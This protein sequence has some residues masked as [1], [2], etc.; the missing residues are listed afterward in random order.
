MF[1]K[2]LWDDNVINAQFKWH[3]FHKSVSKQNFD[4][5]WILLGKSIFL[6]QHTRQIHTG[7][8]ILEYNHRSK[9]GHSLDCTSIHL[10]L[11]NFLYYKVESRLACKICPYCPI[12]ILYCKCIYYPSTR[13]FHI[14]ENRKIF[15]LYNMKILFVKSCIN[16][17]I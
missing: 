14:L 4:L 5:K 11:Y 13:H 3:T 6:E 1:F 2:E 10:E 17:L 7:S 12:G 8:Y 9:L 16:W 15:S